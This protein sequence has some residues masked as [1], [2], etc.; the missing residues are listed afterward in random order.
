MALNDIVNPVKGLL[1]G[2]KA[3]SSSSM[4]V[5]GSSGRQDGGDTFADLKEKAGDLADKAREEATHLA[6]QVQ[7]AASDLQSKAEDLIDRGQDT[8][9]SPTSHAPADGTLPDKIEGEADTAHSHATDIKHDVTSRVDELKTSA[10]A[11]VDDARNEFEERR[12]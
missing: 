3:E 10:E 1:S 7:H 6:D 8:A 5:A 4:N 12:S 9:S 11:H 2:G